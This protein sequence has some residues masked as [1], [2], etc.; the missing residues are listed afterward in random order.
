MKELKVSKLSSLT[1]A[2][3]PYG[4]LFFYTLPSPSFPYLSALFSLPFGGGSLILGKKKKEKLR[5]G[6][7]ATL[8]QTPTGRAAPSPRLIGEPPHL[9]RIEPARRAACGP[10]RP[11][12][13]KRGATAPRPPGGLRPPRAEARV[14][15]AGF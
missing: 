4:K 14:P 3:F 13:E 5:A 2:L 9:Q 11:C 8:P 10:P 7:R 6:A 1:L 12:N 15:S